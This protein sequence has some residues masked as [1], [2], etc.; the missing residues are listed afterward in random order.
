MKKETSCINS[1]AVLGYAR[2]HNH[3][4]I[5]PLIENLDPEINTMLN[6][7][8]YLC[9]QNNWISCRIMAEL[10]KRSRELFGDPFIAFK[11]GKYAVQDSSLGLSQQILLKASLSTRE[12]LIAFH[13]VN[14][15][16]SRNKKLEIV[17]LKHN[18]AAIRLHWNASMHI[19]RDNCIYNQGVFTFMP[20]IWKGSKIELQ[21]TCCFFEGA[22]YCEYI[23]RWAG[24][25]R[26]SAFFDRLFTHSCQHDEIISELEKNRKQVELKY[27]EAR[28]LNSE[29]NKKI[30][31]LEAI[32]ET[33]KAIL[34]IL[35][36]D[37]LL[38]VIMRL[39]FSACKINHTIILLTN[40]SNRMLEYFYGTGFSPGPPSQIKAYRVSLDR[41][42][43]CLAA[44]ANTGKARYLPAAAATGR[45]DNELM[46]ALNAPAALYATPLATG[47]RVIGLI[48][49]DS[50]EADDISRETR[51]TLDIFAS[52]IAIAIQ[53]ARLY[54]K[55]S[56]QMEALKKSNQLL[57]RVERFSFLGN[58]AARL[59][60]EIKNPMTAIRTF[61]QMLPEKFDDAEF[62]TTFQKIALEETE[63]VN[64]LIIELLDLVKT[65]E[66]HFKQTD[67]HA[68]IEKM[69]LLVSPR[70][71]ARR[72]EVD[73]RFSK[74]IGKVTLDEN[75]MKQI[76]L[77]I[78]SNAVEAIPDKGRVEIRTTLFKP[79]NSHRQVEIEI[80]DSGP[81]IPFE[82]EEKIFDPYFSTKHKSKL[83][84]GT[85]LGLFIAHQNIQ[86]HGGTIEINRKYTGGA[87]FKIIIP[88]K[89]ENRPN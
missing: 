58:M 86:A 89:Y 75:K 55:L 14:E 80:R 28:R 68:L 76:I 4:S 23:L 52:Q 56:D 59:A 5:E 32:Q 66:S 39:L 7:D 54:S 26:F 64:G 22:D 78:L 77:N 67:L 16:C 82:I 83:H 31:Q 43:H 25:N 13:G 21:E 62:R 41:K 50:F 88:E 51:D 73:T 27:A 63:R 47:T 12:A 19:T 40:R 33:G 45:L 71:K 17:T 42:N 38:T 3:G 53:N 70:S 34:S 35:D 15:Q 84:K 30:A 18:E 9:D 24:K 36:L 61:I 81:G 79:N 37:E 44:V 65:D 74:N 29:L 48:L 72:I 87:S 46:E 49:T 60:H 8:I 57:S 1:K 2:R 10:F 69:V 11:I 20:Q 85:G 6:P